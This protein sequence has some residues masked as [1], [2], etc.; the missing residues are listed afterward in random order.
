MFVRVGFCFFLFVLRVGCGREEI[1]GIFFYFIRCV[2]FS[3]IFWVFYR[4]CFNYLISVKR[5][6]LIVFLVLN[7]FWFF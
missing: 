4:L 3:Y 1:F 2:W 6:L 7:F 5:K